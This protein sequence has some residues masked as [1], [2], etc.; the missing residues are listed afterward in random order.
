MPLPGKGHSL[1]ARD[2]HPFFVSLAQLDS[3]SETALLPTHKVIPY[4]PRR[5]SATLLPARKTLGIP[6][7]FL[8]VFIHETSKR[9]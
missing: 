2:E 3:W 1:L 8:F 4:L 6:V 5:Q 7:T 9:A